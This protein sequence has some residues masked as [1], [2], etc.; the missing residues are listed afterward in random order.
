MT[1]NAIEREF[2]QKVCEELRLAEESKD[3]FRVFTPFRFD[4]GDH[5]AIVLKREK[6][7]WL[8]S[9]E[10]HT[11]MHLTYRLDGNELENDPRKEIITSALNEFQVEDRYGEYLVKIEQDEYGEALYRLA[12][13]LLR[14][15]DNISYLSRE[16]S[17]ST[18]IKD[19][20]TLI[21]ESVPEDRYV[22][23]WCDRFHDLDGIY[24]VDCRI[25]NM[26]TPVYIYALPSGNDSRVRDATISLYQFGEWENSFTPVA[27]FQDANKVSKNVLNK[28][29]K[30]CTR[31]FPSLQENRHEIVYYLHSLLR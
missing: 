17:K 31:Q 26:A 3:R 14:I 1:V 11:Y 18:F 16:K 7:Q 21:K 28:F 27:V 19:F 13:A 23:D 30:V 8:L 12:Q 6:N 25:N 4:D 9:D 22:F 24:E 20:Q 29:S 10:G 15:S 5:L 2:K